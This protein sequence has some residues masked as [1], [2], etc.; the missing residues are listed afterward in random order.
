MGGKNFNFWKPAARRLSA[1]QRAARSMSG[2][3]SLL[4]LTL[5][6]R[7][8]SHNSAKCLSRL[9]SINSARFIRGALGGYESFR[10]NSHE[11]LSVCIG[12]QKE[13][14][15]AR[16]LSTAVS[17]SMAGPALRTSGRNAGSQMSGKNVGTV[18]RR[19]IA[20]ERRSALEQY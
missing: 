1:T 20:M 15:P 9:P 7:K 13:C 3:C 8:N 19:F 12:Q 2:L 10:I 6:I 17:H 18:V 11:A 14:G 16:R 4:A 5:G